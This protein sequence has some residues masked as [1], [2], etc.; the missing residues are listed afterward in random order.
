MVDVISAVFILAGAGLAVLAGAGLHRF[1][2][3]FARM[4][5]AT[6]PATL[7]LVLVMLGASFHVENAGDIA[8]LLLVVVLQFL[9]AP[10]GGHMLARA[11]Y[12]T[13]M[14]TSPWLTLDELA[15]RSQTHDE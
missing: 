6:K 9:T 4:H 14:A 15:E 1:E 5:A 10:V 3:V 2:D 7:G 12:R 8:K 13:G 11:A